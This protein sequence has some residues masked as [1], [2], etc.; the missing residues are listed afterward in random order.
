MK[1]IVDV[2]KSIAASPGKSVMTILA[3][4]VG[5]GVL[6]LALSVSGYFSGIMEKDLY[7][8]SV[9]LTVA[10]GEFNA[11]GNLEPERPPKFDAQAG[12]TI[13][14]EVSGVQAVSPVLTPRWMELQVEGK[15]YQV[16]NV[17]GVSEAYADIM[18][19]KILLGSMFTTADTNAG[20]KVA[21][22]SESL[23]TMWF[24]SPDA[25]IGKTMQ[26]PSMRPPG[27]DETG[28]PP[29]QTFSVI[30]VMT[31][32]SELRRKAYGVPDII[33]PYTS[34]FPMALSGNAFALRMLNSMQ[35]VQIKGNGIQAAEAQ[36]REVLY[37]NYGDDMLLEVWEGTPNGATGWLAE[38]R[39][40]VATFNLVVNILGFVLLI[41]GAIGILSIMLVEVLGRSREISLERAFG[42]SRSKIVGEFFIRSLVFTLI[43]A[44]VGILL[45]LVFAKP[46]HGVLSPIFSGIS[47]GGNLA[48]INAAGSN[49]AGNTVISP[50]AVLISLVSALAIGG[51][52]G[53]FPVS[54]ALKT[55][56]AEGIRE[57]A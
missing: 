36:I 57:V 8:G 28:P 51:V 18:G 19:I 50:F 34:A 33:I 41:T 21:V 11:E 6:I 38:T 7:G 53:V 32:P 26:P 17:L 27:P 13:S 22:I 48:G 35:V 39:E 15:A 47:D 55:P 54:S 2:L 44:V 43:S 56:I 9:I 46:L 12:N 16:R 42:A 10:N 30:G 1:I 49:A 37:R 20:N 14:T 23:A 24:G 4:G 31:D 5:I 40:T 25:A 29:T 52:F 3:V 45:S